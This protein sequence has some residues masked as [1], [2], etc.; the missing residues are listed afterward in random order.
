MRFM[1]LVHEDQEKIA[2]VPA[3]TMRDLDKEIL[4]YER[5]LRQ[6]G[7]LVASG[8]LSPPETATVIHGPG[9][10]LT[11]TDGPYVETKEHLAGF[12]LLEAADQAEAA[13]LASQFPMV[14][15]GSV[16]EVR[17]HWSLEELADRANRPGE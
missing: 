7:K 9:G 3:A 17:E 13:Q 5:G 14:R 16:M 4:A 1:V 8:P 15:Y 11:M 2:T 10:K 6:S 12:F